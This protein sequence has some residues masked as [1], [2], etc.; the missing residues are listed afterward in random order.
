MVCGVSPAKKAM[1]PLISN[2]IIS[3]VDLHEALPPSR[4]YV[5]PVTTGRELIEMSIVED[6]G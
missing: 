1:M 4:V 5:R 6:G 2:C 3:K